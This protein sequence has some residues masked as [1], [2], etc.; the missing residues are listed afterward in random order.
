MKWK[1]INVLT[2]GQCVEAVAG[3]FHRMGSGGVVIEDPQAARK[4]VN[5]E[6]FVSTS[7]S[8]DFLEHEFVLVK[9]YFN[10]DEE[11]IDQLNSC[12]EKVRNNFNTDCRVFI[13]EVKD[14][15]WEESW[16]KYYHTFKVGSR[17]VIKPSWEEYQP[18]DDE[19]VIELD[20]GMAFGTGIHASTRFCLKFIDKYI[21]GGEKVVDAGCGSGI[22]S[23]AAAKLGADSVFAMDIDGL[24]VRISRENIALN[25]LTDK[26]EAEEGDILEELCQKKPDIIIANITAEVVNCLIPQAAKVLPSGGYFWGS[27]IVDSRW[28]GVQKKLEEYGF[29]IDEVL[30]DV[31]WIGVAARKL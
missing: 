16:K 4:Y 17:L 31:D 15:D 25:G 19:V 23:I 20:P 29:V 6:P 22:L 7:V 14:E 9:A 1:E 24:A 12:L 27:G 10:E 13:D 8:P 26:I 2:E 21:K 18:V 3:I 5:K 11:V 30:T 28:P